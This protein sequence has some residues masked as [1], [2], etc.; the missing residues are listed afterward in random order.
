MKK[1]ILLLSLIS[2]GL[3]AQTDS[4][5]NLRISKLE[6][7]IYRAKAHFVASGT[8]FAVASAINYLNATNSIKKENIKQF[9]NT[10]LFFWGIGSISLITIAID[11]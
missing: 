6:N 2:F 11:F 10:E 3:S 4:T 8:C 7:G 5:I 9:K 1:L